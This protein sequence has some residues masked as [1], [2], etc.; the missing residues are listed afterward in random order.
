MSMFSYLAR[1][2][3]RKAEN[4]GTWL[5]VVGVLLTST[6][7]YYFLPILITDVAEHVMKLLLGFTFLAFATAFVFRDYP[8]PSSALIVGIVGVLAEGVEVNL[9]EV[10]SYLM[11]G[12]LLPAFLGGSLGF[13]WVLLLSYFVAMRVKEKAM[14][15]I[16][17]S[18]LYLVGFVV[19]TSSLI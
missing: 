16:A 7:V 8:K 11:T 12:E 4:L 5:G 9:F 13:F 18:V 19:L 14:K 10:S 1:Q 17:V 3:D 15:A 2:S 6:L